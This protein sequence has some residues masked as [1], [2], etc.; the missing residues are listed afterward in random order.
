[1]SWSARFNQPVAD[2]TAIADAVAAGVAAH[3]GDERHER[4]SKG[5]RR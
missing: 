4:V 5:R 2:V 1:M 3:F